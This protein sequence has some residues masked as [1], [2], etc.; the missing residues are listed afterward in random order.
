MFF[1]KSKTFKDKT[2]ERGK[3]KVGK[4]VNKYARAYY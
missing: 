2:D 4:L 3:F 1:V